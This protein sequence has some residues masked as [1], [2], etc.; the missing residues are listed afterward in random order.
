MTLDPKSVLDLYKVAVDEVHKYHV[1]HQHR[2]A[3]FAGLVSSL[4]AGTVA[5][6]LNAKSS[7]HCLLVA[8]GPVAMFAVCMI[9]LKSIN[10]IYRLIMETVTTRAKL[11]QIIGLSEPPPKTMLPDVVDRCYRATA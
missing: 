10:G 6:L 8:L 4:M 1:L 11:E 7:I 2:V 9:A 3:F 5:G